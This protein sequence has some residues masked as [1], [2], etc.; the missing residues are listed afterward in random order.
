MS[1]SGGLLSDADFPATI[2]LRV[3]RPTAAVAATP[4]ST[5][6]PPLDS[7]APTARRIARAAERIRFN[8]DE[9]ASSRQQIQEPAMAAAVTGTAQRTILAQ[10]LGSAEPI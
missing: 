3:E 6:G 5:L 10:D 9:I 7:A 4:G 2:R 8:G 1:E